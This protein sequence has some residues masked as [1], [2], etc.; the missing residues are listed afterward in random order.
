LVGGG[1]AARDVFD[2]GAAVDQRRHGDELV[3]RMHRSADRVLGKR[4][5]DR[6][7]GCS[8]LQGTL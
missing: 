6:V 5:L 4:G 8:I 7:F 3:G 1:E 2:R